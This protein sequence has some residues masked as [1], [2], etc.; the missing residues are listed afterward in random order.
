MHPLV[1]WAV[2]GVVI[3]GTVGLAARAAAPPGLPAPGDDAPPADWTAPPPGP[4]ARTRDVAAYEGGYVAGWESAAHADATPPTD[5]GVDGHAGWVAGRADHLAYAGGRAGAWTAQ[6]LDPLG[7][8]VPPPTGLVGWGARGWRDG[9]LAVRAVAA[10]EPGVAS[11]DRVVMRVA[12]QAG[13]HAQ[14]AVGLRDVA[15]APAV[16]LPPRWG[17]AD[18]ITGTDLDV[19][20]H[21]AWQEGADLE[22]RRPGLGAWAYARAFLRYS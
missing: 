1:P 11:G 10:R 21:R 6:T 2:G 9:V 4:P 15:A 8:V 7:T 20:A 17:L 19:L 16:V 5:A 13:R 14:Q 22:R 12:F 3:G 18:R